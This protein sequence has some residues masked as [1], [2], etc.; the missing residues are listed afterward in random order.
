MKIS[1][2]I[3]CYGHK[4]LLPELVRSLHRFVAVEI[5]I[6]DDGNPEPISEDFV[7]PRV[8]VIRR[9][10]NE[11]LAAARNTLVAEAVGELVLFLDADVVL[12]T[13]SAPS[14]DEFASDSRL[15]ALTGRA[16]E[17]GTAGV[18]DRWRRWFW[19]QDHGSRVIDVPFAYGLCC[20]WRR[21]VVLEL[22][23]FDEELRSHGEDIDLSLR[24]TDR[25]WRITHD[26]MLVV[27]HKRTDSVYSL[28]KMV[29]FHS[30]FFSLICL[31]HRSPLFRRA[32]VNALKWLPTTVIS[33]LK[34]HHD[35]GMAL[36]SVP[37]CT[38]S[39]VARLWAW[40]EWQS[41]ISG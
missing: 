13:E 5:L 4:D 6:L 18:A 20:I 31:R 11:G 21:T 9:E 33:S 3:P 22:G 39:I 14:F 26:P 15:A 8:R 34:R 32:L 7:D 41:G 29:W 19:T 17:D 35:L 36:I 2:A 10:V 1:I 40:T 27:K 28:L 25:D 16:I 23:G 37:A 12:D 30:Y 38:I 24:A